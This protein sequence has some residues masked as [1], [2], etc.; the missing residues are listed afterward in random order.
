MEKTAGELTR[1]ESRVCSACRQLLLECGRMSKKNNHSDI[2]LIGQYEVTVLEDGR[3]LLPIELQRQLAGS[4]VKKLCPGKIPG[5]K[6]VVL[7]PQQLWNRWA[8]H[9]ETQFPSLKTHPG[10]RAYLTPYKPISWDPQR[11]LSLPAGAHNYASIRPQTTAVILGKDY[12]LE[13]WSEEEFSKVVQDCERQL[14]KPSQQESG[15]SG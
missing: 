11:R 7:C 2:R 10:A 3:I 13:V 12:Y 9:L 15:G 14:A 5:M 4:G 6:A 8:N 1:H